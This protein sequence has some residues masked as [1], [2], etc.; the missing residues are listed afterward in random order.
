MLFDHGSSHVLLCIPYRSSRPDGEPKV[1]MLTQYPVC[2]WLY[3][4]DVGSWVSHTFRNTALILPLYFRSAPCLSLS[5]PH[6]QKMTPRGWTVRGSSLTSDLACE[7]SK[8]M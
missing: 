5:H 2:W 7:I 6:P 4:V 1:C 3:D 8:H